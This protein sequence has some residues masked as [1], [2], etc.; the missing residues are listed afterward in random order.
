MTTEITAAA[1]A[2]AEA[3][4][5]AEAAGVG[6]AE[7]EAARD[8]VQ[9]RVAA[10]EAERGEILA[11]R[12]ADIDDAAHGPRL[13][14]IG[15]DLENLA[16]MQAAAVRRVVAARAVADGVNC[17]IAAADWA[18]GRATDAELLR[19]L[20]DHAG[21]LERLLAGTVTEIKN[22]SQKLGM[23]EPWAPRS[24]MVQTLRRLEWNR[25]QE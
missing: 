10:L 18:L 6:L 19:R 9:R 4:R 5:K 12:M 1:S 17:T 20:V 25:V 24:D 13:A 23:R 16:E 8:Q 21:K 2:L 15:A 3:R 11:E 22:L 14:L 7:A